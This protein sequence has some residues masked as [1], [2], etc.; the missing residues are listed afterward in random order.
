MPQDTSTSH[1]SS[2]N[3]AAQRRLRRHVKPMPSEGD[4]GLF[5]E[6]WFPVCMSDELK[7]GEI[8]GK[9]FL[10][11]RVV[12]YRD[13]SGTAHV[14]SS[15]CPHLGAD[16]SKGSVAGDNIRC[17][18]HGFE[19]APGGHCVKTGIGANPPPAAC[20]FSFTVVERYGL[21]WAYN[22]ETPKWQLPD[23][24]YPDDELHIIVKEYGVFP[25]DPYVLCC[26]T[27]DYHHYRSVHGLD[28]THP[29]PDPLQDFRWTDH[30]FRFDLD[31]THWHGKEMK[32]TF[33]IDSVSLYF[34]QGTLDGKW[35]GYLA[36][37]GVIGASQTMTYFVV[38]THKGD[39][40]PT[41]LEAA[42]T[43]ADESMALEFAFVDQDIP[44]LDGIHFAQGALTEKDRSLSMY[45]DLVRRQPRVHP[46]A[47]FIR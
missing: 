7:I 10:D 14:Q 12:I 9:P 41:A 11:G 33:G 5:T 4:D 3:P 43:F 21:L 18:F 20:L 13:Q 23:F 26:N 34:Q 44:V 36:P 47:D 37:F 28:W 8:L 27:P 46:S 22:G 38:V 1:K 42:S 16:L 32:F 45:L 30:G 31:G 35:Y 2:T 24:T 29:D 40:S 17:A 15:Y 25:A 39:G 19:Y 6:A